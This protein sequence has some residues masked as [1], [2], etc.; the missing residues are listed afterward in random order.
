MS[1]ANAADPIADVSAPIH[2]QADW[3]QDWQEGVAR[4]GLFRGQCRVAQG[5][6]EYL[7]TRW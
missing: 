3:S 2:L 4:V 1:T 6:R 7:A 5:D